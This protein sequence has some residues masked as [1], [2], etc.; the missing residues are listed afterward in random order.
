MSLLF[1]RSKCPVW[2]P[3][4]QRRRFRRPMVDVSG[5]WELS[6]WSFYGTHVYC[7]PAVNRQAGIDL[8]LDIG[9]NNY[10]TRYQDLLERCRPPIGQFSGSVDCDMTLKCFRRD[11]EGE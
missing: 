2:W 5:Q 8:F 11:T 1:C 3:F 6:I 4:W 7:C 10:I 9:M